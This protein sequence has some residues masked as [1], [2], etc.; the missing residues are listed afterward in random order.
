MKGSNDWKTDDID[1]MSKHSKELISTQEQEEV[2]KYQDQHLQTI[3][4]SLKV[5]TDTLQF[6]KDREQEGKET[7]LLRDLSSAAS[8]YEKDKNINPKRVDGT[9]NWFFTHPLFCDWRDSTKP[10]L[11]WFSAGPGCGK[12]VLSRSLIDEGHLQKNFATTT[13]TASTLVTSPPSTICYFFSK[14]V[15]SAGWTTHT[16]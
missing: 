1:D 9:C 11:L 3:E 12:S 2:R 13:L 14:I 8:D 15:T 6:L 16:L 4:E 5:Q 10:G 7:N